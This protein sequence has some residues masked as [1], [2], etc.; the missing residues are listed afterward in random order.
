MRGLEG[1][2]TAV[3]DKIENIMSKYR[4]YGIALCMCF[5]AYTQV[6]GQDLNELLSSFE[7]AQDDNARTQYG[8]KIA[9]AYYNESQIE[10]ALKYYSKV[11]TLE[12]KQ[13][14]PKNLATVYE[15]MGNVYQSWQGY[16]KATHY[17]K[18]ALNL[19]EKE[20]NINGQKNCLRQMA[21]ASFKLNQDRKSVV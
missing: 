19:Y 12:R 8:L 9:R 1:Y 4:K 14:T 6:W 7:K 10:N 17:F 15:E 5:L 2:L 18:E 3:P 21:W 16:D 11:E 13:K 20:N